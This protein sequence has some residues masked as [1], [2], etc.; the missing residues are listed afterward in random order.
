M[1]T[2]CN[3]TWLLL[4]LRGGVYFCTPWNQGWPCDLHWPTGCG[5]SYVVW[6]QNQASGGI[7]ACA[8]TLLDQG[9]RPSCCEDSQSNPLEGERPLEAEPNGLAD[10]QHQLSVTWMRP[11]WV[12][13]PRWVVKWL[14]PQKWPRQDQ[15]M[16][17][18]AYP[19]PNCWLNTLVVTL[20]Q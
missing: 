14:Q 9:L 19:C 17:L 20:S 11:S 12:P 7:V 18:P 16:N 3:G 13:N 1:P 4:P 8:V 10:N 15:Q 5:G 2:L 6:L